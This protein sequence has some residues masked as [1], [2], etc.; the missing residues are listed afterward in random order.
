MVLFRCK[1]AE[2]RGNPW[3]FLLKS[4]EKE[5]FDSGREFGS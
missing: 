1:K 2:G 4:K 5:V 3:S